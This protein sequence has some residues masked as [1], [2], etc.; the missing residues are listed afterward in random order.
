LWFHQARAFPGEV[1]ILPEIARCPLL[2]PHD[3]K[4]DSTPSRNH[5]TAVE[6]SSGLL[7]GVEW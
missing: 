2:V 6:E 1:Y 4:V 5:P 3:A 7:G